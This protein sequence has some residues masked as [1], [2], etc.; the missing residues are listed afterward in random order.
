MGN[1]S[2]ASS[3]TS[4]EPNRVLSMVIGISSL[5]WAARLPEEVEK[6]LLDD[7]GAGVQGRLVDVLLHREVDEG[8][9][10][11]RVLGVGQELGGG[12]LDLLKA[13][14]GGL[15]AVGRG[16]HGRARLRQRRQVG[17]ESLQVGAAQVVAVGD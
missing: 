5:R 15:E 13:R 2:T 10:H 16:P 4:S 12:L 7:V 6:R 9:G 14:V 17:V 3:G 8:L 1:S 11:V